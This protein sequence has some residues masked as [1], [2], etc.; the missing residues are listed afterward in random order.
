M[1]FATR[2]MLAGSLALGAAACV[3]APPIVAA[4]GSCPDLLPGEWEKGVEPADAPPEAPPKPADV[5]AQ[6]DWTLEQLKNW[7]SFGNES[8]ARLGMANDRYRDAVGIVRRCDARNAKAIRGA[9]SKVLG[10]F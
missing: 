8:D 10:V 5:K 1:R 7:V 4:A 3:S 2:L 9:R 6:L